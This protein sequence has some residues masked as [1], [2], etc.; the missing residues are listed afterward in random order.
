MPSTVTSIVSGPGARWMIASNARLLCA[1]PDAKPAKEQRN[2]APEQEERV[3][4]MPV[5][6]VIDTT[7][8]EDAEVPRFSAET[9]ND[10]GFPAMS[11][12]RFSAATVTTTSPPCAAAPSAGSTMAARASKRRMVECYDYRGRLGW[13]LCDIRGANPGLK[14]PMAPVDASRTWAEDVG[15]ETHTIPHANL[16]IPNEDH[17]PFDA[18]RLHM[19]GCRPMPPYGTTNCEPA[20]GSWLRWSN[21]SQLRSVGRLLTARA[22]PMPQTFFC[23]LRS[24]A[25]AWRN[26][27]RSRR[28]W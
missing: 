22:A 19:I 13:N 21:S 11:A 27:G 1:P 10:V 23:R 15:H 4:S 16:D 3:I 7:T 17:I 26:H 12:T 25:F 9:M 2:A 28:F 6:T 14:T 5:G 24:S 20:V 8:G 18:S